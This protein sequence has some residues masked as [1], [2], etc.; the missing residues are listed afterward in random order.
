MEERSQRKLLN[1][2]APLDT[3]DQKTYKAFASMAGLGCVAGC[4]PLNSDLEP[5]RLEM[6]PMQLV[7]HVSERRNENL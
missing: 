6:Q 5:A 7:V 1:P 3:I 2:Q 4:L